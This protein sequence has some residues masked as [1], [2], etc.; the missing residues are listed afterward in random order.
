MAFLDVPDWLHNK[1]RKWYDALNLYEWRLRTRMALTVNGD[2]DVL[3]S[4]TQQCNINTASLT[5]RADAEDDEKWERVAL[6]ELLH[7]LHARTDQYVE[8][9]LLPQLPEGMREMSRTAYHNVVEA[10]TDQLTHIVYELEYPD[11]TE[12]Y[13]DDANP[14]PTDPPE[15]QGDDQTNE[16]PAE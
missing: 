2:E 12:G 14:P 7:V 5:F 9:V 16:K 15:S 3:A 6:H 10:Y 11:S 13:S 4:C 1:I 8:E